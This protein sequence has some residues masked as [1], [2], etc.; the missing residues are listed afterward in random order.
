MGCKNSTEKAPAPIAPNRNPSASGAGGPG[1]QRTN[2]AT[3]YMSSL[4]ST[5]HFCGKQIPQKEY[6]AHTIHCD[7]RIVTCGN[8]WCRERVRQGELDSHMELCAKRQT[9]ICGKCGKQVLAMN[10]QEHYDACIPLQCP[11][12]PER[13]ISRILKYCPVAILAKQ[14]LASGTFFGD[15]VTAKFLAEKPENPTAI[16]NANV[17]KIQHLWRWVKTKALLEDIIFRLIHKEMD[18]KKEGFAIFKAHD[19]DRETSRKSRSVL[20]QPQ[21]PSIENHYFPIKSPITIDHILRMVRDVCNNILL[22]YSAAWRVFTDALNLLGS[23]PN[24]TRLTPPAGARLV[25]GRWYQGGKTVVVGDLHGQLADLLHIM[26]ECGMP[27]ESTYYVF[28]GDFVD[29]GAQGVEVLLVLFTLLVAFPK[30]VALNRGNHECDYMNEEYGFDV[31]VSTKY[32]R[33]M[34]RL[35]QR[36]FCALPLATLIG[37]KVF[38]VHGGIPRRPGVTIA[39]ISKLQRFRQIPMPEH[40]QPEEDEM[41]QDM[42]WSDPFDALGWQESD[43]GAGVQFGADVTLSFLEKNELDLVIRSHEEYVKGYEE[44][45][46]GKLVTVFSASN[47]NGVDTNNGAFIVLA[48]DIA[49]PSFHTFSV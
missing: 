33:N 45:H 20:Q 21:I 32:D 5:C 8:N 44:H 25:K 46:G 2:S 35:I 3:K 40:S 10:L 47:Y 13:C 27:S 18:L 38:V 17:A 9:A 39:E 1:A 22:P 43:R 34:F 28:N 14:P 49:E 29:R 4:T 24:V 26:R 19:S 36:C 48:G 31:E 6:K 7:E 16:Q 30:Y 42:L 11:Y 23:L 37:T 12:C 15:Q 41:Y